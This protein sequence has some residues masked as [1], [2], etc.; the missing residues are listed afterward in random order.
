MWYPATCWPLVA[1]FKTS[2]E[3]QCHKQKSASAVRVHDSCY[4]DK[5]GHQQENERWGFETLLLRGVTILMSSGELSVWIPAIAAAAGSITAVQVKTVETN[6]WIHTTS[7]ALVFTPNKTLKEYVIKLNTVT[8]WFLG[9]FGNHLFLVWDEDRVSRKQIRLRP[10][11][12]WDAKV[13]F[14][15]KPCPLNSSTC[16]SPSMNSCLCVWP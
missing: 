11:F 3:S 12:L 4:R 14:P 8:G 15:F 9:A 7:A 1:T 6:I 13:N 2:G 5:T 16:T 10:L